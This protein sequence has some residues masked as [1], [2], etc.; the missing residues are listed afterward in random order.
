MDKKLIITIAR[1]YGSG[2]KLIGQKL[3]ESLNI[4]FY[5]KELLTLAAKESGIH[6][7]LF[8]EADENHS[9]GFW[10][11]MSF[12]TSS[13]GNVFSG[14]S[15]LPINDRLFLI[16]SSIIKDIAQA[17]SCVIVGR[18][19]DYILQHH[20]DAMHVFIHALEKDKIARIIETY[21]V[22]EKDARTAMLKTDKRRA[23]YYN[24][25]ADGK[26]GQ[27]EN[28]DL[29][30]DSSVIGIDGTVMLIKEFAKLKQVKDGLSQDL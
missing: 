21:G 1:E 14:G 23:T 20:P 5:D 28:Y 17:G 10:N 26:W 16:Q 12:T 7:D 25:Y 22:N 8:K 13:F 9:K 6:E 15:E 3:S 18:C 30:I 4:P 2:G 29:S 11:S 27:A 19:A 24:Y